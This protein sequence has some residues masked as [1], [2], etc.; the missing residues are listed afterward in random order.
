MGW[1]ISVLWLPSLAD[2]YGRMWLYRISVLITLVVFSLI[3]FINNIY[4]I[5][6]IMG[7]I[8][9]FSA[10]RVQIGYVY[11]MEFVPLQS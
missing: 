2:V 6:V 3:F 5:I 8:G 9:F 1:S 4:G 10:V 11:M 7:I